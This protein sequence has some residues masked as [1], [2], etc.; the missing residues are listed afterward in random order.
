MFSF[1]FMA[2]CGAVQ[3][4]KPYKCDA[5]PRFTMQFA[6]D[7]TVA[8]FCNLKV[9][10]KDSEDN[11][12]DKNLQVLV[13]TYRERGN[14]LTVSFGARRDRRGL[15]EWGLEADPDSKA[16]EDLL[17]EILKWDVVTFQVQNKGAKL[18]CNY[19]GTTWS[20]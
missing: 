4:K 13:G 17:R 10:K 14:L 5:E 16:P 2:S 1:I 12:Q 8:I 18:T 9:K 7:K 19:D 6:A 11:Y 15:A 20:K 3:T